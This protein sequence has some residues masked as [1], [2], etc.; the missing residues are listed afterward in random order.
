MTIK[1]Q[2]RQNSPPPSTEPARGE[3]LTFVRYAAYIFLGIFSFFMAAGHFFGDMDRKILAAILAHQ[4]G[5]TTWMGLVEDG[6]P[7]PN[8][9]GQ[10]TVWV[11]HP[12]WWASD[13][14]S[15]DGIELMPFL[16][17]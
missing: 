7:A 2:H 10:V 13:E 5:N 12:G 15:D 17:S 16:T 8:W 1:R 6:S 3:Y 9:Y 4:L 14:L 11:L